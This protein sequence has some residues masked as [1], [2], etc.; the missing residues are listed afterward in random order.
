VLVV[1]LVARDVGVLDLLVAQAQRQQHAV[2]GEG[3]G[4]GQGEAAQL[5]PGLGLPRRARIEGQRN[6]PGRMVEIAF[7][8]IAPACVALANGGLL[9]DV[10]VAQDGTVAD[11][12]GGEGRAQAGL[13]V[14]VVEGVGQSTGA[15]DE[16][17]VG[18]GDVDYRG[19]RVAAAEPR[20][21]E[22]G[23]GRQLVA[24]V[25]LALEHH[26]GVLVL[27]DLAEQDG[28]IRIRRLDDAFAAEDDHRLRVVY[29]GGLAQHVQR[30]AQ[31][32]AAEVQPQGARA[33][34]RIAVVP[35]RLAVAVQGVGAYAPFLVLAEA[36]PQVDVGAELRIGDVAGGH[37]GQ[38]LVAGPLGHQVDVAAQVAARAHAVEHGVQAL[39]DLHALVQ[40]GGLLVHA[41]GLHAVEGHRAQVGRV[42]EAAHQHAAAGRP[43]ARA[44]VLHRGV[45]GQHV[46]QRL[47][48]L[49]LDQL[50]SEA[51]LAEGRVH[52]ILAAQQAD[53]RAARDLAARVGGQRIVGHA[54]AAGDGD[55]GQGGHAAGRGRPHHGRAGLDL[56]RQPA[57][58]QQPVQGLL[59]RHPARHGGRAAAGDLAGLHHQLDAG[60]A[61]PFVQ[62]LGERLGGDGDGLRLGRR[63][64]LGLGVGRA[65]GKGQRHG[66]GQRGGVEA[67]QGHGKTGSGKKGNTTPSQVDAREARI[68]MPRVF[69]GRRRYRRGADGATQA[70]RR[71][72]APLVR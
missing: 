16:I 23:E 21:A 50:R 5:Y 15:G 17:A 48:L 12:A 29:G 61:R 35:G 13:V 6:G 26:A 4:V 3:Q 10:V 65:G 2:F 20:L 7:Y 31:P 54:Q 8:P 43:V 38:R 9:L 63:R 72:R 51:G 57:A 66:Q 46:G 69:C 37:A 47:G 52:E 40:L 49:V 27:D 36:P 14:V 45:V 62:R 71:V 68:P 33:Q 30:G 44:A 24:D 32:A 70:P 34:A 67:G 55:G 1:A 53:P 60:L 64:G 41:A 11:G 39:G 28:R 18:I 59:G 22:A 25:V 19:A 42:G 56:R 58:G